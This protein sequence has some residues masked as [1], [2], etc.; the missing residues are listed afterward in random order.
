MKAPR[1][2]IELER[3]CE[4]FFDASSVPEAV[5]REVREAAEAEAY[6]TVDD[7][8][9]FREVIRLIYR[10][11]ETFCDGYDE[12][13]ADDPFTTA[14]NRHLEELAERNDYVNDLRNNVVYME[15]V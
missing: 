5:A 14:Y 15:G 13:T 4:E 2:W 6:E 9:D 12:T 8:D 11:V 3:A 7:R 1:S 10:Y